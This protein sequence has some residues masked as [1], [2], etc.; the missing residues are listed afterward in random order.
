MKNNII[1]LSPTNKKW[2]LSDKPG[3]VSTI[4]RKM[5]FTNALLVD[6]LKSSTQNVDILVEN[7]KIAEIAPHGKLKFEGDFINLYKSYVLPAFFDACQLKKEFASSGTE[8]LMEKAFSM[9]M[10]LSGVTS[11]LTPL[12]ED[13]LILENISQMTEQDLAD[14][15]QKCAKSKKVIF[16]KVGQTLEELGSIDK[17]FGKPLAQVLEDFGFL[18]RKFVLV[19]GNCFEKDD[20]ELFSQYGNKFVICPAEDARQ[21]RRPINLKT[22]TNLGFDVRLGTGTA[23]QADFFALMRQVLCTQWQFFEENSSI[24]ETDL[25]MMAT[26]NFSTL[27]VGTPANFVVVKNVP[28]LFSNVNEMLVWEKSKEDV[29]LTVWDGKIMQEYISKEDQLKTIEEIKRRN[30]K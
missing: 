24:S 7:G 3:E 11:C 20:L 12:Q 19:G 29:L 18:D 28:S 16:L 1:K 2:E 4:A 17:A 27:Q 30:K 25:L 21:A 13:C 10:L 14:L 23:F 8:A 5:A 9:E 6:I 22:L 26:D 15:C